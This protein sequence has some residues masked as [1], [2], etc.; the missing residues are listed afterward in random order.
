MPELPEV[1]TTVNGLNARVLG[2]TIASAWTDWPPLIREPS[3]TDFV[4]R[5]TGATVLRA[6]RRGK[7]IFIDLD[8]EETLHVHMKMTGHLLFGSWVRTKE[9]TKH[10]AQNS[11]E[12]QPYWIAV[13]PGAMRDDPGNR[14][15]RLMMTFTDSTQLALCDMRRFAKV[16]LYP[17]QS[18]EERREIGLLGPEPLDNAF[19]KETLGN[20]L[21][22]KTARP[23][24][25]FLMDQTKIAGIGNIYSDEMLFRAGIHPRRR[26]SSLNAKEVALLHT[27]MRDV[28][29]AGLD[30]GGDSDV[31]YRN[32]DGERGRFQSEH[33]AYRRTGKPCKKRGCAG[34]ITREIIGG[35]SAHFCPGHQHRKE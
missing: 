4:K 19:T 27:A 24:K 22:N 26:P 3:S 7:N 10:K 31:D 13:E 14:F 29:R 15:I 21:H 33:H 18:L 17:T 11:K 32:I 9:S 6:R 1:Q 8:T 2:K 20:I 30:F 12:F 25:Q 5:L 35:R 28:L 23:I 34:I 16:G